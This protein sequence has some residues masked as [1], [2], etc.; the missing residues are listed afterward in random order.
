MSELVFSIISEGLTLIN[1]V[2]PEECV[3]IQGRLN[4]FRRQWDEEYS[5]GVLRD[6][7]LLDMLTRELQYTGQLY[8]AAVKTAASKN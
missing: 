2:V 5:K 4:D 3:R 1:K 6:D 7:A 8:L